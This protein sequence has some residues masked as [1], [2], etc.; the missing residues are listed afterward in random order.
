MRSFKSLLLSVLTVGLLSACASLPQQAY[1]PSERQ[2]IKTI[3]LLTPSLPTDLDVRMMV[4]PGASFGLIGALVA[5]GNMSGKS[6]KFTANA[7]SH[8]FSA[9]REMARQVTTALQSAG[10]TVV[11]ISVNRD[12]GTQDFLEGYALAN[13]PQVDAYLDLYANLVGY[14][15]AGATTAYRPTVRVGA[16]LVRAADQ[17]TLYTDHIWYNPFG[18]PKDSITLTANT[19]FDYGDFDALMADSQRAVTG[20]QEA[21]KATSE[22]LGQQLR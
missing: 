6:K 15:A 5:E 4:H 11:P 19:Q 1:D 3:G 10:Y 20:L 13:A 14:T 18:E 17:Q 9:H 8:H 2:Q 22:A 12:S 21:I 16:K 7:R